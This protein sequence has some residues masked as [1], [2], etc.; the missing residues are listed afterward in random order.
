MRVMRLVWRRCGGRVVGCAV[1]G[2]VLG[3]DVKLVLFCGIELLA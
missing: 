2:I 1:R 3:H